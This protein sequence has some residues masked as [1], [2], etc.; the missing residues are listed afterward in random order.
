M[1][2]VL[3]PIAVFNLFY[4]RRRSVYDLHHSILGFAIRLEEDSA[5]QRITYL[6]LVQTYTL[7]ACTVDLLLFGLIMQKSNSSLVCRNWVDWLNWMELSEFK[8]RVLKN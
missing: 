7:S 6:N 8:N 1:Y 4:I 3:L 2:A 5:I